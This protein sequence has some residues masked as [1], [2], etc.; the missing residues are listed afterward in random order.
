MKIAAYIDKGIME[1]KEIP[2]PKPNDDE[3]LVKVSYCGIC[4]SDIHQVQYG[5]E[6]PGDLMMGHE[7]TGIIAE[8]GRNVQGW[9]EGDRAIV[10]RVW[11]CGACWYCHNHLPQL[12]PNKHA[13]SNGGYAEYLTCTPE[14]LFPIPNEVS[15][16]A[17]SLWNPMTNSIHGVQLSRLKMAD[18]AIVL[19][20]GPIGLFTIAAAR[21]AGAFPVIAAE[22]Q[23]KR[24]EA[25]RKLGA[26]AV[27]NPL[28]DNLLQAC[29]HV[30]E[31]GADLVY[32]CAGGAETLQEAIQLVRCG[33]QV[34]L[35]GIHMEFFSFS[36]ILWVMKEV[37]VQAAFGTTN[38]IPIVIEMLRDGAVNANDVVSN[39]ISLDDLPVMMK[40]LFG[41]NDEI[42]V[43]VQP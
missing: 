30:Q 26:H 29:Q 2:V 31:Y 36:S 39:I 43:L 14:H 5:M 13:T 1:I 40:K 17:A 7:I 33:G 4:G 21:R 42:K 41:Q 19:G 37:D 16:E 28:E 32:D 11:R 9:N 20:A 8:V 23:P 24:A 34:I 12:C 22:I 10:S 6:E 18:F 3:L 38:Q 35:L 27:L 25:A 15:L